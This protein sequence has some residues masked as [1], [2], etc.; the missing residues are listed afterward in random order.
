MAFNFSTAVVLVNNLGGRGPKPDKEKALRFGKIAKLK[1]DWLDLVVTARG[2]Y[3]PVGTNRNG[4]QGEYGNIAMQSGTIV[5]FDFELV[6][7]ETSTPANLKSF[8]F[9]I[10]DLDMGKGQVAEELTVG[11][12]EK[13][14]VSEDTELSISKESDRTRFTATTEGV[15]M[16]NPTDPLKLTPVQA[17][18]AVTFLFKDASK[19]SMT[20]S[21]GSAKFSHTRFFL[22]AGRSLVVEEDCGPPAPPPSTRRRRRTKSPT[23]PARRRRRGASR[24]RTKRKGRRRRAPKK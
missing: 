12:F 16:D 7:A 11:G 20:F 4:V 5:D 10:Y 3:A 21:V 17:N 8:Y 6:T 15:E 14:F 1:D 22:F 2:T 18:R 23:G 13:Y 19:F 9:S 24:R